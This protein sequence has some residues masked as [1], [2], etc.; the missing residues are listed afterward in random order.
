MNQPTRIPERRIKREYIHRA[1]LP[2]TQGSDEVRLRE[3]GS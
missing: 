3:I 1:R 2:D